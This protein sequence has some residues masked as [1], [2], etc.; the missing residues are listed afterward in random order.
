MTSD[1]IVS[2][3]ETDSSARDARLARNLAVF[4][5]FA[6]R[7]HARLV[8]F[9]EPASRLNVSEQ[10]ALDIAIGERGLY[11]GDA[12]AYTER[13][14]R[15]F[16]A[17]PERVHLS[18]RNN[19]KL[20]GV[21]GEFAT[22][23]VDHAEACGV[24]LGM[25]RLRAN[26]GFLFV[27]GAGLGLHL[28]PIVE[29]M[30]CRDLVIVEPNLE[31]I[32]HSLEVVEW[33]PIFEIVE[34]AGGSVHFVLERDEGTISSRIRDIVRETGTSF[35]DGAYIYSHYESAT[36]DAARE[37]FHKD[38]PLHIY[39]LGF[40][41]DE[42]I[43]MS[44]AVANLGHGTARVIASPLPVRGTPVVMCGSGPSLNESI[45]FV[46][47][48][49]EKVILVSL[50]S[51]LRA[52][53]AR[54]ME[55]DYHVEL[56]NELANAQNIRGAVEEFGPLEN[57]TLIASAS[58]RPETAMHFDDIIYYFRDRVSSSMVLSSGADPL[59]A[60]GPAV[61][62]AA[63][64]ALLY[65]GFRKL[66]LFGVDMGSR[67]REVY[68]AD[69]TYIGMGKM[70]EWGVGNRT[71]VPANFGGTAYSEGILNWSRFTFENVIRLHRDLECINCSDGVRIAHAV[72]RL[73]RLVDFPAGPLDRAA[74]KQRIADGLPVYSGAHCRGLWKR[75]AFAR[76]ADTLF[77]E[78][79]GVL[80]GAADA[81]PDDFS[82]AHELYTLTNFDTC[83]GPP[84]RAFLFGTTVMMLACLYWVDGRLADDVG[85]AAFRAAAM[86]RLQQTYG[87]LHGGYRELLDDVDGYFDGRL[88]AGELTRARAA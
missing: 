20:L 76:H 78:I 47:A 1:A 66:Y 22:W 11:G 84:T 74:V 77:G 33:T 43:M 41:E 29:R 19:D 57:T 72:P 10:G 67:E 40:Y 73:A 30:K 35:L 13:Q 71:S 86:A 88:D 24:D 61:A 9:G 23:A 28:Q 45:E 54:G 38:F 50:G 56:E 37:A 81:A 2:R 7:L 51:C 3:P 55:P 75:D 79:E 44:N 87:R 39:G 15:A 8:H 31:Y 62:N 53:R 64:M 58:V 6:A 49:R 85:R 70:P 34:S 42:L 52:I 65:L 83:D 36:I 48:N 82:W 18:M 5:R 21:A 12:A 25:S 17:A 69:D 14:L 60:C 46:A 26:G 59:G 27:F 4:E 68:H 63:L 16:V 32:R 80:A